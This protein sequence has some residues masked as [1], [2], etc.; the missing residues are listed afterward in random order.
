MQKKRFLIQVHF[1]KKTD[2]SSKITE[3]ENKIRSISGLASSSTNSVLTAA[4]NEIPKGSN[5]V[6]E[7]D[8]NTKKSETEKKTMDCKHGKHII[9]SEFYK[10]AAQ[11][12]K[13]R[14]KQ[15]YLVTKT[16]YDTKFHDISRRITSNKSTHLI[17]ENELKRLQKCDSSYFKVK[18]CFGDQGTQ[19]CLESQTM[20]K[21]YKNW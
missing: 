19:N 5:L 18:N 6:K 13:A 7:K 4:K 15:A 3:I 8:H 10:L 14:L 12:F 21:C 11:N 9:T 2:F 16:E 1:L 20:N 17:V